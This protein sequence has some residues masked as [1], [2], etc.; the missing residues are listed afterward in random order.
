MAQAIQKRYGH[1][2]ILVNN[3]GITRAHTM[4]TMTDD[5]WETVIQTNLS[6]VFYVS[7]AIVPLMGRNAR[8]VNMASVYGLIGEYGLT[9]YCASKAGVIGFT[10]ALAREL[11]P[12][13]ITVNAVC[14][15]LTDTGMIAAVPDKERTR[16]LAHIALGRIGTKEEVAHLV[17]FLCSPQAAYITGQAIGINGG[18]E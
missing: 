3:A 14:P 17:A 8:I 12:K 2:N 15:G 13:G 9:N 5:E 18:M 1:V 7:R 10:K 16:R 11:G 6:G 4:L